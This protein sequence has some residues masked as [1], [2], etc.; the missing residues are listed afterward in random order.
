[1]RKFAKALGVAAMIAL[2]TP[3]AAQE[4]TNISI[5]TGGLAG[6]ITRSAAGSRTC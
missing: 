1:M 4:K 5:A 2:C 3:L 6:C